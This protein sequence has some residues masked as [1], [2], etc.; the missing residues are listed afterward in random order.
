MSTGELLLLIFGGIGA[1]IVNTMAGGGSLLTVPLLAIAGL[2]G[3]LANGTNRLG[4][5][6]QSGTSSVSFHRQGIRAWRLALPVLGPAVIGGLVGSALVA[7]INDELFERIFGFLM[8]PLLVLALW[9]PKAEKAAAPWPLWQTALVF[10]GIGFYAGAVQAGTGLLLLLVLSRAGHDLVTGNAIKTLVIFGITCIAL[11]V[12][13]WNDDV[14][15]LPGIVLAA[16]S[17]V[18]GW[19]GARVA[20]KGGERVIKPVLAVSV[21][22]LAT[23]MIGLWG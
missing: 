13:I 8:I 6:L 9:K 21:L 2:E 1:G 10:F 14:E 3:N 15:W 18:G 23:R 4:V 17:A 7:Q 11:S 12:F 22:V 16:G 5:L 19:L 20:V